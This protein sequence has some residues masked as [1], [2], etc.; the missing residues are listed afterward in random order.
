PGRLPAR[1]RSG[2]LSIQMPATLSDL[3][4][5]LA[6]EVLSVVAP[7]RGA[8]PVVTDV[9]LYDA[10][11]A[12][13]IPAGS[14]V[15]VPGLGALASPRALVAAL[16]RAGAVALAAKSCERL[17]DELLPDAERAGIALL[18][19]PSAAAWGQVLGIVQSA[20]GAR[21]ELGAAG[22]TEAGDLFAAANA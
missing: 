6:P 8:D 13:R 9:V 15:L 20:I 19:I 22:G 3:L 5:R 18:S 17:R 4:R 7:A 14:L 2:S 21:E 12:A 1:R 10:D 16:A 11:E